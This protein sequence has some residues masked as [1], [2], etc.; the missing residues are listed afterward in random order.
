MKIVLIGG[1]SHVGKTSL[2]DS[3]GARLGWARISTD[4]LARHPGRPWGPH[5]EKLPAHVAQHYLSL[6]ANELF[7]DVLLHYRNNVWPKV[8]NIVASHLS[9]ASEAG[10]I[11]EGSAIWP[12][13]LPGMKLDTIAALWLTANEDVFTERVWKGSQY[14]SKSRM[15][16]AM[17]DKFL[18]R[19]LVYDA[20]MVDAVN[21][22]SL[23]LV[24]VLQSDVA[25]LTQ[26]CLPL[27]DLA[28]SNS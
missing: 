11:L 22:N 5:P 10:L 4:S 8:E 24:D 23:T 15:E 12:E 13:F 19:T 1:S 20:L 26:R 16:R 14:G 9:S 28:E 18:E 6:S 3:L 25:E 21:R 27:L 2:A 7:E 17:V